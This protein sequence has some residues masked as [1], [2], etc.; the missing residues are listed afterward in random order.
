MIGDN[1]QKLTRLNARLEL[2][3]EAEARALEAQSTGNA[4]GEQ[5]AVASLSSIRALIRDL[6]E[7]IA[8]IEGQSAGVTL[9]W[10]MRE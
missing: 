7:Q 3:Y 9:F 2:A 1:E 4:E 8:T 5:H 10:G 6:E